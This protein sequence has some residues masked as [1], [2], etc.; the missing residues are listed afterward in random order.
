MQSPPGP[1]EP[2]GLTGRKATDQFREVNQ[3]AGLD[4]QELCC[5]TLER[6]GFSSGEAV[7]EGVGPKVDHVGKEGFGE[8]TEKQ[9]LSQFNLCSAELG[10]LR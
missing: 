6:E 4:G 1:G 2:A 10:P 3:Y 5:L 9:N 7:A 8:A